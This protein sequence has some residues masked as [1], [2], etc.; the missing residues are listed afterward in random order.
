MA[1]LVYILSDWNQTNYGMSP[2]DND[3]G[4]M[5]LPLMLK[6]FTPAAVSIIGTI[7][8]I[9]IPIKAVLRVSF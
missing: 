9:I 2:V 7:F 8:H 5:V 1:V 4:S 3:Q 6:E